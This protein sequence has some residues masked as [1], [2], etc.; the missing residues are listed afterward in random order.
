[1]SNY[2]KLIDNDKE[3]TIFVFSSAN[4]PEGKFTGSN[5]F[6]KDWNVVLINTAD[7]DWYLRGIPNVEGGIN[8]SL[9]YIN[10]LTKKFQKKGKV[11]FFGS[12]MGACGSLYY[13]AKCNADYI[14]AFSPELNLGVK[15]GFFTKE[16]K[17]KDL[18]NDKVDYFDAIKNSKAKAF[19]FCGENNSVDCLSLV[20]FSSLDNVQKYSLI[21]SEHVVVKEI[22]ETFNLI[23]LIDEIIGNTFEGI[24]DFLRTSDLLQYPQIVNA[25]YEFDINNNSDEILKVDTKN[26]SRAIKSYVFRRL[27][28]IYDKKGDRINAYNYAKYSYLL[29]KDCGKSATI[30]SR[31]LYR[32]SEISKALSILSP[33]LLTSNV[34]IGKP[35]FQ[36][37]FIALDCC[38]KLAYKQEY[39]FF[40]NRLLNTVPANGG[41]SL[42]FKKYDRELL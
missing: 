10:S 15:G 29:N 3:N 39:N 12:S 19:L 8:K 26:L 9:E 5:I 36:A 2:C 7:N 27:A 11:V 14:L 35:Y 20:R 17:V 25:L 1:M 4:V 40:Y 18:I 38:K 24:L 32:N 42:K 34:D 22:N 33:I 21:N 28:L 13:G 30:Y 31:F 37:Y 6:K 23:N 16:C 41:I